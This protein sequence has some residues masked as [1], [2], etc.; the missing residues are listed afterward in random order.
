MKTIEEKLSPI[1]E[2]VLDIFRD[3][4]LSFWEGI[5]VCEM[6]EESLRAVLRYDAEQEGII[7]M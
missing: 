5:M 7:D 2:K 1:S 4:K 3:K 6:V